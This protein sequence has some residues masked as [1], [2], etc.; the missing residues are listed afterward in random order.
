VRDDSS[1]F[2][3]YRAQTITEAFDLLGDDFIAED[4]FACTVEIIAKLRRVATCCEVP[5]ALHY[6]HKLKASEMRI[7]PTIASYL[8][9][10]AGVWRLDLGGRLGALTRPT[11][12]AYA[13]LAGTIVL[14]VLGQTLLKAGVGGADGSAG[15]AEIA[16]HVAS[17]PV[18]AGVACYGLSAVLWLAVLTQMN[19][20]VAYPMGAASYVLVLLV[21]SA[22]GESVP[23]LRWLG[24]VCIVIGIAFVGVGFE[25]R[26]P[27]TRR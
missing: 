25:L 18:L 8:R 24:V 9:V 3:L 19:L 1:G 10:V 23:P 14:G 2:R 21:A 16:R 22:M 4:G 12:A 27:E 17:L 6:E 15:L 5:F 26:A 7:V 11:K 13:A 20:S